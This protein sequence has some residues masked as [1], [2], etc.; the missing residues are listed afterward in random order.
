M[1]RDYKEEYRRYHSKP[2][3]IRKRSARNKARRIVA[4]RLGKKRIQGKDVDHKRSLRN[5]GSNSARNLRLLSPSR[6]RGYKR[7]SKGRPIGAA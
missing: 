1:A 2:S 5:G 3:Q 7:N 4:K 6:N